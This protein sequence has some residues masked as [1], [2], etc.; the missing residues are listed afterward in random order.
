MGPLLDVK[1][2]RTEKSAMVMFRVGW[3]LREDGK[4]SD[5]ERISVQAVKINTEILGDDH[6]DT[7][8]TMDNLALT[9]GDQGRTAEAA[10][11]HE[12][13]LE[14]SRRILGDDHPATL[15]TMNNLAS[16]YWAQGR[17]AEAAALHEEVLEK[18]RRILGDDHP[19]TLTTMNNLAST[20]GAQG[21]TAEAGRAARGG[22]GEEEADPGRRPSLHADDHEQPL[23]RRTGPRGGRRRRPLLHEEVLEKS[24]QILGDDHPSTLTTMNNLAE[25][26]RAQGRMVEAEP[27]RAQAFFAQHCLYNTSKIA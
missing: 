7:L 12:E 4:I 9:Y 20:Y 24:R 25:T 19:S 8:T 14:K 17:T 1:I 21:R 16:T 2:I 13:V 3:F 10:A 6:P 11:L 18:S 22:A 26:Y 23:R 15:T 5:S 27:S